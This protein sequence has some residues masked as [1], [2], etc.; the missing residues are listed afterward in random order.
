M[1]QLLNEAVVPAEV[2]TPVIELPPAPEVVKVEQKAAAPKEQ[3]AKKEKIKP[4]TKKK[5]LIIT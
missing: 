1:V 4:V 2:E 5:K 3:V